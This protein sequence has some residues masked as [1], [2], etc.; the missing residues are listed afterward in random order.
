MIIDVVNGTRDMEMAMTFGVPH[1]GTASYLAERISSFGQTLQNVPQV[2]QAMYGDLKKSFNAFF[3][4]EAIANARKVL[5]SIDHGNAV[6]YIGALLTLEAVQ[7]ASLANQRWVMAHPTLRDMYHHQQI[8]GYSDTYVD[9]D[10][11]MIGDRH[12]DYRRAIDGLTIEQPDG[13]FLCTIY[14]DELKEGDFDLTINEQVRIQD[15]WR[16]LSDYLAQKRK[17]LEDPTSQSGGML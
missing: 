11:G 3:S 15:T 7:K 12:Y 8:D 10:P 16:F 5:G 14:G 6:A 9:V 4:S 13:E 2:V 1:Y 17:D